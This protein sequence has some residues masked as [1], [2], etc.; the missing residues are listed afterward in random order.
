MKLEILEKK[1]IKIQQREEE[2]K[3]FSSVT[4]LRTIN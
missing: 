1:K 3:S 4:H 2:Q